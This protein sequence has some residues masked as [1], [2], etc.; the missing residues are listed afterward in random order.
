MLS[1]DDLRQIAE[2]QQE[3]LQRQVNQGM[4]KK[5]WEQGVAALGGM[6]A[7]A[8]FLRLCEQRAGMYAQHEARQVERRARRKPGSNITTLPPSSP[9]VRK[10]I[11]TGVPPE[12]QP[13]WSTERIKAKA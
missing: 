6:E 10:R 13:G 11:K 2:G 8:E 1:L 7:V 12:E 9:A 5:D 3:D 4:R